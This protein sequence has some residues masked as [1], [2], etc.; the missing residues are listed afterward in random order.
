MPMNTDTISSILRTFNL[1][2]TPVR[3]AVLGVL[4]DSDS[5]LS[6]ADISQLLSAQ[7]FDKV[8]LYRTLNHFTEKGIVHKVATE[9][10]NWL[11]A[12]LVRNDADFQPDHAH[13]HFVCDDCEKI[14]CFPIDEHT[15]KRVNTIREG[16]LVKQ[17]EIRLHGTCPSC[18]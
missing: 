13:A 17:Q 15:S 2:V 12:I 3:V 11:Y 9:D 10:R 18:L 4:L 14:F 6:H 8:T 7:Q 5:A 1:K 16:F